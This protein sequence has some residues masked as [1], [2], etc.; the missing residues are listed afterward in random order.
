MPERY[1]T[2][3]IIAALAMAGVLASACAK[4]NE[5][6]ARPGAGEPTLDEVRKLTD[7]FRDVE[8]ALKE[9]Y[10]RDP[11][12]TCETAD[13]MGRPASDGA[14]GVHYFRPDVL[15]VNSAPGS[16]VDGTGTHIDFRQPS[17]L[18]YEPQQDGSMQLVAVENLAFM[19]SWK[20]AGHAE[21]PSFH[22]VPFDPMVDDPATA[23]DEAHMFAPH[24]DRHVWVYRDNPKGVFAQF[25]PTVSCTHHRGAK[26]HAGHTT[27]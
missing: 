18:I 12:D 10:I 7:R 3:H 27:P 20:A 17:V 6:A 22:G 9:G 16:R 14:M 13:M 11:T 19:A 23:Y 5:S 2:T 26:G 15:G 8:V 21:P 24:F 4:T 25:N 1:A